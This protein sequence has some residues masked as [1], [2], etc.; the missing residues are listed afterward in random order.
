MIFIELSNA[1]FRFA[2]RCAGAE[3]GGGIQ[4]L[5]PIRWWKIQRSIR[6]RVIRCA[7]ISVLAVHFFASSCHSFPVIKFGHG[8]TDRWRQRVLACSVGLKVDNNILV[9]LIKTIFSAL[10]M[11]LTLAGT[12]HFASFH[13]TR[14]GGV[15]PPL[16]I[17]PLIELE[18]RGETS[19]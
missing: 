11:I 8:M 14:G 3:I 16:A 12:G 18:L 10:G 17:S 9:S 19:V 2:L 6:T 15:R 7:P 4:T 1:V 5:S 13:G